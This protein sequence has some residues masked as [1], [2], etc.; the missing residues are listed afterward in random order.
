MSKRGPDITYLNGASI[1]L[2]EKWPVKGIFA[3]ER[4]SDPNLYRESLKSSEGEWQD[5]YS[6]FTTDLSS[7]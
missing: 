7:K 1:S 3:H 6:R 5:L 2:D 4:K